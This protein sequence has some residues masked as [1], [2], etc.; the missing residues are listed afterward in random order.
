MDSLDHFGL[1]AHVYQLHE[2]VCCIYLDIV[3]Y[4]TTLDCKMGETKELFP[5]TSVVVVHCHC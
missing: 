2:I 3:C 1:H 5:V 4:V